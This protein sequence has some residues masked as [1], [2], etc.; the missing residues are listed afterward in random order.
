[1]SA[2]EE[3]VYHPKAP[4]QEGL[5]AGAIGAGV[6]LLVSAAQNSVGS[7]S[8]GATGVFA[9]TG[10]TIG[11]F[12]AMAGVFAAT[13]SAVAN[14]RQTK[15]AWN[16]VAA[17][18]ASGLVA[19]GFQRNAQTMVFGCLGMGTMMGIF[20]L[21]GNSLKGKYAEIAEQQKQEWRESQLKTK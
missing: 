12:A 10:G 18:C 9:R 20:D 2:L 16:S 1:M 17:G 13:D 14:A 21:S 5:Q 7:H 11:I 6:G 4:I 15:D 19:G 3:V 8:Y